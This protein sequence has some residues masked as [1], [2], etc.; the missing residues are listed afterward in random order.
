MGKLSLYCRLGRVLTV[1]PTIETETKMVERTSKKKKFRKS[2]KFDRD[3]CGLR[4][5]EEKTV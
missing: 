4:F 3:M 1:I 5:I 2:L